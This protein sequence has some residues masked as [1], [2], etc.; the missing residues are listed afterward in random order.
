MQTKKPRGCSCHRICLHSIKSRWKWFPSSPWTAHRGPVRQVDGVADALM[1]YNN[2]IALPGILAV[3]QVE[4][5]SS[6]LQEH[7]N[8]YLSL[9]PS[10]GMATSPSSMYTLLFPAPWE[11]LLSKWCAFPFLYN[12]SGLQQ[13]ANKGQQ[14][15]GQ[16][17]RLLQEKISPKCSAWPA[18]VSHAL[19]LQS[20]NSPYKVHWRSSTGIVHFYR[21]T[22][23]RADSQHALGSEAVHM[24]TDLALQS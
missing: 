12:M 20:H 15:C 17:V 8:M 5:I 21:E 1:L 18:F 10:K 9:L 14:W 11:L 6:V 13:K 7:R 23:P 24:Q 22:A 2:S 4:I 3:A 16:W 19:A